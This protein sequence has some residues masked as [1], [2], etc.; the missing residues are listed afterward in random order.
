MQASINQFIKH[1]YKT[2]EILLLFTFDTTFEILLLANSTTSKLQ[3]KYTTTSK[4]Y[5]HL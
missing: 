1:Y 3:V 5:K 4:L 2:F